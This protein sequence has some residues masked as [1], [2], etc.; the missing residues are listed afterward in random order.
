MARGR[1]VW[2]VGALALIG[3]LSALAPAGAQV[4]APGGPRVATVASGLQVPWE[5]AFLPDG[6]ALITERPGR[7]RLMTASRRLLATPAAVVAVRDRGEGGLLGL[8]VDPDF[9]R[10]RYVYLYR[11]TDSGN[12]IVR[13]RMT[14]S[15]LLAPRVIVAGVPVGNTHDGGRIHFGPDR[16]LY[17]A[18]GD[19]RQEALSQNRGSLAGKLLRLSPGAYRGTA[20]ARPQIVSIGHRNPQ[21]FDWQPGTGRLVAT[22]HGPEGFDEINLIRPGGNYGWPGVFGTARRAGTIGPVALYPQAI[23]PSGATFVTQPGSLWSGDFLVGALRGEQI[24]RLRLRGGRVVLNQ[25]LFV[26]R[27]GRIRTVVEAPDGSLLAL[28]NNRDGRGSPRA[29]DDRVLRIVPPAR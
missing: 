29:G 2:L 6:R 1:A 22:E 19:T 15:R 12:E 3:A 21:G 27:Y 10:T 9:R 8:A 5:I 13:Y 24:R 23:A 20:R 28:T 14:G 11:S 26:G 17:I 4:R 7:V 25:G 16:W 18:T